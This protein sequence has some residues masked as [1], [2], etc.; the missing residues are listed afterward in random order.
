MFLRES[1]G[2]VS[3]PSRI[4]VAIPAKDEEDRIE[5]CL[6]ALDAQRDLSGTRLPR[7]TFSVL[8]L[9]NN[10]TDGTAARAA[11]LKP[12]LSF[13]LHILPIDLPP[14][15]AHAGGARRLALGLAA[16][17]LE[18]DGFSDG[19]LLTSDADS[20]AAPDWI[21]RNL[22]AIEAGADAVAGHFVLD[23]HEE[24]ML[25]A[26]LRRRERQEAAYRALLCE[27]E[28]RLDR[29]ASEPWPRHA[30]ESG[31]SIAMHLSAYRAVGGVPSIALGEDKA[32]LAE[33]RAHGFRVRHDPTVAV[34]TSA[35]LV[36]RAAGGAAD[37]MR[38][39]S[40]DPA[41]LC[42]DDLPPLLPAMMRFLSNV[43][44]Y[45]KRP[46]PARRL[47]PRQLPSQIRMAKALLALLRG[48]SALHR[49]R[50][51]RIREKVAPASNGVG[52]TAAS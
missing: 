12:S 27:L 14:Q 48:F 29:R 11:R 42:N 19:I 30:T 22:A 5:D 13:E 49:L 20:R 46:A 7:G 25:P 36:G 43:A 51:F 26:P 40:D 9:I 15:K 31:A 6:L 24:A 52:I 44:P 2:A 17:L 28:A 18:A 1:C 32:L 41:D 23:P 10:S 21:A 8:L 35:R 39:R 4:L 37:T 16:L 45:L 38:R 33:F 34:V 50:F 3:L 47:H